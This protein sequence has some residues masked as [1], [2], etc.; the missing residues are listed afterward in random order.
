MCFLTYT[1]VT[2]R[3]VIFFLS[4]LHLFRLS[5]LSL[6]PCE[7]QRLPPDET[8]ART[9]RHFTENHLQFSSLAETQ[10]GKQT[11]AIIILMT[12]QSARAVLRKHLHS[13]RCAFENRNALLQR[14]ISA[15]GLAPRRIAKKGVAKKGSVGDRGRASC[16]VHRGI[17]KFLIPGSSWRNLVIPLP[18]TISEEIAGSSRQRS[19]YFYRRK[20]LLDRLF[21]SER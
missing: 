11:G 15:D 5:L 19:A 8:N 7:E 2:C 9:Y 16:A 1:F 6:R 3:D 14:G 18:S 13:M 17:A 4:E 21:H 20:S 10:K 12:S